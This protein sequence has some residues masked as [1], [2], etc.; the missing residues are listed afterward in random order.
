MGSATDYSFE[1]WT[2]TDPSAIEGNMKWQE[3]KPKT[4][5]ETDVDIKIT[6]CGMCGS[7]L[8]FLSNGWVRSPPNSALYCS[9]L[10]AWKPP[11]NIVVS[12]KIRPYMLMRII[13]R[14]KL[15]SHSWS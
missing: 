1:G 2:A 13:G 14:D 7:D 8:H 4:W 6:H 12:T 11:P 9:N 15:A 10:N 3:I 5:E